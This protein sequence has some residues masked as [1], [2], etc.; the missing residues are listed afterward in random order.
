MQKFF[1]CAFLDL[2]VAW[3]WHFPF[4]SLPRLCF[5]WCQCCQNRLCFGICWAFASNKMQGADVCILFY[6]FKLLKILPSTQKLPAFRFLHFEFCLA[7]LPLRHVV[8]KLSRLRKMNKKGSLWESIRIVWVGIAITPTTMFCCF[9]LENFQKQR[10][11]NLDTK[12]KPM[13]TWMK[14][15]KCF[16]S[17]IQ[18]HNA[19]RLNVTIYF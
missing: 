12:P 6:L 11:Y 4:A 14:P 19:L 17:T 10:K 15:A 7:L 18:S 8:T 2:F 5:I 9:L 1:S 16:L 13:C 3:C